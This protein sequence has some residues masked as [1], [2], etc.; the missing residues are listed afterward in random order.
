[1]AEVQIQDILEGGSF[2]MVSSL[3][4][5]LWWAKLWINQEYLWG[6]AGC[7]LF[8]VLFSLFSYG[9]S[10]FLVIGSLNSLCLPKRSFE[11][12]TVQIF[13]VNIKQFSEFCIK[14]L[15]L[16]LTLMMNHPSSLTSTSDEVP[17]KKC[18]IFPCLI[19]CAGSTYVLYFLGI[20]TPSDIWL[21]L[22]VL[23]NLSLMLWCKNFQNHM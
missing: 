22:P 5:V 10:P 20:W 1:M 11:V 3:W 15:N 7:D 4:N 17:V 14:H 12:S 18:N 23:S 8:I 16:W 21:Q 6:K 9:F 19:I 13:L 2:F